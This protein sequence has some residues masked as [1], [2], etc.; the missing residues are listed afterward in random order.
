[1]AA[2]SGAGIWLSCRDSFIPL[3]VLCVVRLKSFDRA[4]L[5]LTHLD[6]EI[7]LICAMVFKDTTIDTGGLEL[8][9]RIARIAVAL[10]LSASGVGCDCLRG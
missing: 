4:H 8:I 1:M 9:E 10:R 2:M 7:V 3:L 5:S 6:A